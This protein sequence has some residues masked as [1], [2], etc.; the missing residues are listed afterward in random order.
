MK[1]QITDNDL[2]EGFL[3]GSLSNEQNAFFDER[4]KSD[5]AFVE[6][7]AHR[8][9]LQKS[10][11]EATKRI[12]LKNHIRSIISDEKR[13]AANQ[14]TFWL[15]AASITILVGIG[16]FLIFKPKQTL[17]NIAKQDSLP[18]E[19]QL[20]SPNKTNIVEFGTLDTLHQQNEDIKTLLPAEGAVFSQTDTILFSRQNVDVNEMLTI[21][22]KTG[23]VIFKT[24]IQSGT[25][26]CK[27]L[28]FALKPGTY[29]WNFEHANISHTIII[30]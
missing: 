2:I 13:K 17:N 28:P 21:T 18:Q 16:S 9:L 23:S 5:K 6:A 12:E 29:I 15:I 20:V 26:K 1:T 10:Y 14:R 4:V 25:A 30:K 19:D 8:Q 24:T 11:I 27:V 22:D 3:D 7:L